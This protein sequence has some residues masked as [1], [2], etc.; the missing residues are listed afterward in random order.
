[1]K[2]LQDIMYDNHSI[3]YMADWW[4]IEE[5]GVAYPSFDSLYSSTVMVK[6]NCINSH[7]ERKTFSFGQFPNIEPYEYN[8]MK[9]YRIMGTNEKQ[10]PDIRYYVINGTNNAT[11][12]TWPIESAAIKAAEA[13]VKEYPSSFY[14]VAKT[15]TKSKSLTVIT[16]RIE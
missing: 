10:N 4:S 14:Y 11:H 9:G 12:S 7:G 6:I 5:C 1:M 8:G 13:A 15:I 3:W 2:T 16:E